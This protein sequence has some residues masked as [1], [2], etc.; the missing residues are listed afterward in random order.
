KCGY[1]DAILKSLLT[2]GSIEIGNQLQWVEDGAQVEHEP[3]VVNPPDD[4][5]IR[6]AK[7]LRNSSCTQAFMFDGNNDGRQLFRWQSATA[8]LR[9]RVFKHKTKAVSHRGLKLWQNSFAKLAD[10]IQMTGEGL[11]SRNRLG[12]VR[13]LVVK[14]ESGLQRG[15][16]EFA[17]AQGALQM[18]LVD[19]ADPL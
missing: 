9:S 6:G 17:A 5:R 1:G 13:R 19:P 18:I 3:I 4:W 8:D 16:G 14:S 10:F 15:Q 11:Q 7:L 2:L 12:D